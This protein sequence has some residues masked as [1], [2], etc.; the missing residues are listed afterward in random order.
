MKRQINVLVPA[1]LRDDFKSACRSAR[2]NMSEVLASSMDTIGELSIADDPETAMANCRF[3]LPEGICERYNGTLGAHIRFAMRRELGA[4]PAVLTKD[5]IA[6]TARDDAAR[7]ARRREA[8]S[9]ADR[10]FDMAARFDAGETLGDI[11]ARY[12]M[13]RSGVSR[14]ISRTLTR[15]RKNAILP[16]TETSP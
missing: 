8:R 11:A 6:A 3:S 4:F 5:K 7:S 13:T 9:R 1:K 12:K 2:M 15:S 16:E 10:N 14:A